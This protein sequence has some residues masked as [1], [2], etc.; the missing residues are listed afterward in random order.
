MIASANCPYGKITCDGCNH[1]GTG[2]CHYNV[3]RT[4][5]ITTDQQQNIYDAK[6]NKFMQLSKETLVKIIIGRRSF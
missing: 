3:Q 5:T 1:L 4:F 2:G 6:F